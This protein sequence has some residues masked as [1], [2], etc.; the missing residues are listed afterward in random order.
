MSF[1]LGILNR[2]FRRISL[3]NIFL[4]I[5][6]AVTQPIECHLEVKNVK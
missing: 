5:R 3:D 4:E 2:F 1:L 6:G